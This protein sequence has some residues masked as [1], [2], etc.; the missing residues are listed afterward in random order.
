MRRARA[1]FRPEKLLA[2]LVSLGL[3]PEGEETNK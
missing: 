3:V 2:V 1:G